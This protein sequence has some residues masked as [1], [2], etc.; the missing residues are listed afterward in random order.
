MTISVSFSL[1]KAAQPEDRGLS[2]RLSAGFL[3]HILSPT[4]LKTNWLSVFTKLYNSSIA[5]SISLSLEWQVWL[6]SSENN[7]HAV[8]RSLSSGASVY[9]CSM[10]FYLVPYCQPSPPTWFLPITAIVM[11]HFR[12]FW[13]GMFG[14]V[15]SQYTTII[16]EVAKTKS[17]LEISKITGRYHKIGKSL[18]RL[19]QKVCMRSDKSHWKVVLQLFFFHELSGKRW[20]VR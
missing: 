11:C 19:Q 17:T 12:R 9:D 20:I 16:S 8:H 4:G 18:L 10:G 5:H 6:S 3:Y 1:S 7:C 13:N 14:R 15:E 2:F